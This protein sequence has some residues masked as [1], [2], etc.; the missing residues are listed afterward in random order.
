MENVKALVFVAAV[1][2][3]V[4]ES[5]LDL[6]TRY[7]GS[8][9][10]SSLNAPIVLASGAKDLY[11]RHDKFR[12]QLAADVP[13]SKAKVMAFTQRPVTDAALSGRATGSAWKSIPSWFV[14][15]DKDNAIPPRILGEMAKRANSRETI[16]LKGGSHDV[17]VSHPREV[18]QMI[19][20]AASG[21]NR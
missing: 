8:T 17:M 15:G 3:E 4:G 18:A 12:E 10:A 9:L 6:A 13:A 11:V 1:A 5:T 7:P 16:V 19:E 14:Y 21:N 2:P 20:D